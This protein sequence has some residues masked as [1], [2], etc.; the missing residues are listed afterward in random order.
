[1][2]RKPMRL[3]RWIAFDGVGLI[4]PV[5]D[6][7]D[8]GN[9]SLH[10]S[11]DS[12]TESAFKATEDPHGGGSHAT[13]DQDAFLP[14]MDVFADFV[15]FWQTS[16]LLLLD[17]PSFPQHN[18][19]ANLTFPVGFGRPDHFDASG[20]TSFMPFIY[21]NDITFSIEASATGDITVDKLFLGIGFP[22]NGTFS[23]FNVYG[24]QTFSDFVRENNIPSGTRMA[25]NYG[26][27]P[28]S[29][30]YTGT[31]QVGTVMEVFPGYFSLI[32]TEHVARSYIAGGA[33]R[34]GFTT[35]AT[36]EDVAIILSSLLYTPNAS[37]A[38]GGDSF[39]VSL[40]HDL[41][42]TAYTPNKLIG[43]ENCAF[44][45]GKSAGGIQDATKPC[46]TTGTV[47]DDG[48]TTPELPPGPSEPDPGPGDE[49]PTEP[50]EPTKPRPDPENPTDPHVP[51]TDGQDRQTD[52][53]GDGDLAIDDGDPLEGRGGEELEVWYSFIDDRDEEEDRG[54][55]L[56]A[57][58]KASPLVEAAEQGEERDD[59]GQVD[60]LPEDV[61][62][63]ARQPWRKPWASS[64]VSRPS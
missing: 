4:D 17:F 10:S 23:L 6:A 13:D 31:V 44:V 58:E 51:P 62:R 54:E 12:P 15:P 36:H 25:V 42:G 34:F 33:L 50:V 53:S 20:L 60:F 45:E 22:E 28:D 63:E 19:A 29:G 21:D 40:F 56:S 16:N 26:A 2:F 30:I 32:H 18:G 14:I 46:D 41:T 8:D 11:E 55:E 3:E 38:E 7:V 64:A 47:L 49:D 57:S 27:I 5:A 39:A 59:G 35:D 9:D 61:L 37:Q 52:D 43:G 48:G 24:S 1:M